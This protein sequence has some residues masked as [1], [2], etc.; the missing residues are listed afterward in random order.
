MVR[1][2]DAIAKLSVVLTAVAL[3]TAQFGYAKADTAPTFS[4]KEINVEWVQIASDPF[5]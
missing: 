3:V 5:L 2:V 4:F 1:V